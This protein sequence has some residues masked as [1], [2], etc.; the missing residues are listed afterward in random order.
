MTRLTC[1]GVFEPFLTFSNGL[2]NPLVFSDIRY[3]PNDAFFAGHRERRARNH[4][5]EHFSGLLPKFNLLT[6]QVSK[7][8][9]LLNDLSPHCG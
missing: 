5:I 6:T 1:P 9:H 8:I 2:L 3:N 4:Y 7:G